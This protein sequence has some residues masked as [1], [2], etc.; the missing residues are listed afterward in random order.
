MLIFECTKFF[1]GSDKKSFFVGFVCSFTYLFTYFVDQGWSNASDYNCTPNET[2]QDNC[3]TCICSNDGKSAACTLMRCPGPQELPEVSTSNVQ[4]SPATTDISPPESQISTTEG[5][6]EHIENNNHVCTPNDVK[7]QVCQSN[8]NLSRY[9]ELFLK[10]S[11]TFE[12]L[13]S[14]SMRGKWNWLVLYKATLSVKWFKWK[15]QTCSA[16]TSFKL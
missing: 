15:P 4:L 5:S 16:I 12:G 7:M 8:C 9:F 6:L 14:L 2:F 1:F 13:Q 3:N 10:P 11:T